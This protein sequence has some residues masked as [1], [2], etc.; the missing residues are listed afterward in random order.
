[1]SQYTDRGPFNDPARDA[2]ATRETEDGERVL[3]PDLNDALVDSAEADVI[4]SGAYDDDD[5]DDDDDDEY[6][7]P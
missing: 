5:E 4:A 1:M 3:D 6:A 2:A 7:G